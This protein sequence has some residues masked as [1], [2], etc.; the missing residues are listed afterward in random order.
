MATPQRPIRRPGPVLLALLFVLAGLG[1]AFL[2]RTIPEPS[3]T[4]DAIGPRVWP[5]ALALFWMAIS[6]FLL[7]RAVIRPGQEPSVARDRT[8][9]AVMGGSVGY[10]LLMPLLGYLLSTIAAAAFTLVVFG[11]SRLWVLALFPTV[12]GGTLAAGLT[13]LLGVPLP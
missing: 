3:I 6:A 11:E 2:V 9:Y 4:R 12:I 10:V 1:A 7:A 5:M 8:A 13:Q